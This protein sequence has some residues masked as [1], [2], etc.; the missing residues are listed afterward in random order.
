M[1]I[2]YFLEK[3]RWCKMIKQRKA[4]NLRRRM[5]RNQRKGKKLKKLKKNYQIQKLF[6]LYNW[7]RVFLK[8]ELRQLEM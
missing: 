4:L 1:Q 6:K 7:R 8:I 2:E 5:K 3:K